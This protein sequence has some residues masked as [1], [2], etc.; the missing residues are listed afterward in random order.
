MGRG[1]STLNSADLIEHVAET[2]DVDKG[3]AKRAVAAVLA[4][5]VNA[6]K[7]GDEVNLAG[8]GKF[9]VKERPARRGRNPATGEAIEIPASRKIGFTPA[10]QLKDA[11]AE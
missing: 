1:V 11:I 9:K 10:K 7:T 2:A 4:G 6:A 5:I 8:F 3:A